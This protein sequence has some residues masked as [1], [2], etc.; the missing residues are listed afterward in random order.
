MPGS[1]DHFGNF[2][3]WTDKKLAEAERQYP[4]G[5]LRGDELRAEIN[6]RRGRSEHLYTLWATVAAAISALGSMIAAIASLLALR[7]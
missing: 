6:R 4:V 1:D 5:D 3:R 7:H 2:S